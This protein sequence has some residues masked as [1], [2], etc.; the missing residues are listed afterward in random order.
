[1]AKIGKFSNNGTTIYPQ[2]I[3]EAVAVAGNTLS[4]ELDK[5]ANKSEVVINNSTDK[6]LLGSLFEVSH[7]TGIH[8]GHVYIGTTE[9]SNN[10]TISDVVI[11]GTVN[12]NN[13]TTFYPNSVEIGAS[14]NINDIQIGD[15]HFSQTITL[16]SAT[17]NGIQIGTNGN[18]MIGSANHGIS[19][20]SDGLLSLNGK[21]GVFIG[22]SGST[23][24]MGITTSLILIG[25]QST[26]I[27]V[28]ESNIVLGSTNV[29]G[30]SIGSS[31]NIN[32]GTQASGCNLGSS[33]G[34]IGL[35][36]GRIH[37]GTGTNK[38]ETQISNF[39]TTEIKAVDATAK[40]GSTSLRLDTNGAFLGF[41]D[42]DRAEEDPRGI[43][44]KPKGTGTEVSIDARHIGLTSVNGVNIYD[45]ESA[46]PINLKADID[47]HKLIITCGSKKAEI[48]LS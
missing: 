18:I 40:N 47:N 35:G 27:R 6:V 28:D 14:S 5:K 30:I 4:A 24:E 1:M 45:G 16:G 2:T 19:I 23:I 13:S 37:L 44:I 7:D 39:R 15:P 42:G 12:I 10:N 43:T 21:S 41:A 31:G 38:N 34:Y 25:T 48:I 46:T 11:M 32:I 36:E 20:G 9:Y 29:G 22:M 3:A 33:Y 17:S 26:G 8:S